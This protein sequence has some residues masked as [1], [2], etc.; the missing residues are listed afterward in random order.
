LAEIKEK[1]ATMQADVRR[2][3]EKMLEG[4][5][6]KQAADPAAAPISLGQLMRQ[7]TVQPGGVGA[8]GGSFGPGLGGGGVRV[9]D[10]AAQWPERRVSP[11]DDTLREKL[12]SYPAENEVGDTMDVLES[13]SDEERVNLKAFGDDEIINRRPG[14]ELD[15]ALSHLAAGGLEEKGLVEPYPADRQP[16]GGQIRFMHLTERGRDVARLLSASGDPP[17]YLPN[18]KEIRANTPERL[19]GYQAAA[20]SS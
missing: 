2:I 11:D 1:A 3:D 19:P 5:L 12:K 13:L 16:A 4:L 17:D 10:E 7:A 8:T 9:T 6:A 15:P 14:A 20:R 18:L